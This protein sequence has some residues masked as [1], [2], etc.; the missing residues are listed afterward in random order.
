MVPPEIERSFTGTF[1]IRCLPWLTFAVTSLS[2]KSLKSKN[3]SG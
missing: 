2:V 1:K 3:S